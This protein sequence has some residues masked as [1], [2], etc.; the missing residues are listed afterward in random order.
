MGLLAWLSSRSHKPALD[1]VLDG[2]Y[3]AKVLTR[4]ICRGQQQ[5]DLQPEPTMNN[6]HHATLHYML[7]QHF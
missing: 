3:W 5:D 4:R 6:L 1:T 7:F 2:R